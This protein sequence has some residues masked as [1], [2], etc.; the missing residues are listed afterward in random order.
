MFAPIHPH[1]YQTTQTIQPRLRRLEIEQRYESDLV[2]QNTYTGRQLLLRL[3]EYATFGEDWD[4]YGAK[5]ISPRAVAAARDL[6][7]TVF[8]AFYDSGAPDGL[9]NPLA[10]PAI[11][12]PSPDGAIH[13]VWQQGNRELAVDVYDMDAYAYLLVTPVQ[14]SDGM[15]HTYKEETVTSLAMMVANIRAFI[16]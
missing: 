12:T 6:L 13:F 14:A 16:R 2:L 10:L 5:P 15:V 3:K 4:T 8:A 7:F 1:S 11:V 9:S